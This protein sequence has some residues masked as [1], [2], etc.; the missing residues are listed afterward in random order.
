[1]T[2]SKKII[3]YGFNTIFYT[4]NIHIYQIIGKPTPERP[5][6]HRGIIFIENTKKI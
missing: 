5:L 1:M 4:L 6:P 3:L 2:L